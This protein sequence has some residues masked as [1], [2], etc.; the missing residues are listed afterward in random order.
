MILLDVGLPVL[1]GIEAA[2]QILKESPGTKILFLSENTCPDVVKEALR[3]GG[4]VT[5]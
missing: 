4:S 2:K 5:W 3:V 1:N